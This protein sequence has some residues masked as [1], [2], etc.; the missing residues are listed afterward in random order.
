[1]GWK[2][3]DSKDEITYFGFN[4]FD[5]DNPYDPG[6]NNPKVMVYNYSLLALLIDDFVYQEDH[7]SW[8]N[9]RQ[10]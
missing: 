8:I 10:L 4:L 7:Y 5:P 9:G 1:M 2:H 6:Q 3:T